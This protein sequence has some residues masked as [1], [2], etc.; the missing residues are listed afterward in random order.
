VFASLTS[1]K[2]GD[3]DVAETARMAA[4]AMLPWLREFDGYC[5]LLMLADPETGRVQV[6][7]MWESKEAADRSERGRT[8]VRESMVE[9]TRAEIESVDLYHVVLEDRRS[10]APG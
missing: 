2:G 5:G 3:S 10:P 7:S 8:Q 9:T 6:L 1:I 4:E